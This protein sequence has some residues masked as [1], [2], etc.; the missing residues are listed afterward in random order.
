MENGGFVSYFERRF[1]YK[2]FLFPKRQRAISVE[3]PRARCAKAGAVSGI[4]R[5]SSAILDGEAGKWA[6]IA[7]SCVSNWNSVLF[8]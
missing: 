4:R 6:F 2:Q 5:I 1:H 8:Q 7:Q 3:A